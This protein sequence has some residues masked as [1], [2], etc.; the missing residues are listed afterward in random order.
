MKISLSMLKSIWLF[1]VVILLMVGRGL[2]VPVLVIFIILALAAPLI[3]E[4]RKRTDLDERQIHISRFS[5][6]IAFYIYIALVLLVMVNKF[7]AKGENPSNEFYML[8][9]VPMV[10]KFFISVFQNYDSIKAARL[11]GYLFGGSWLLFII[12]SHGVSIKFIIEALPFLLLI[13]AALLSSRYPRPSGIVYTVLGLATVYIYIK[14]NF[15][16]YMKLIMV[17]ILSLPLLLSGIAMFL[18]VKYKK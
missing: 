14:V 10:I 17:S 3:R 16:I 1:L 7:I 18:S 5:S 6:H 13:A 11:I 9:L 4:F 15:D 2:P 12:L 8:L